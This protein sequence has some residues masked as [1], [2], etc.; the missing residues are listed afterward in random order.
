[1]IEGLG[2]FDFDYKM[3]YEQSIFKELY[4]RSPI[5]FVDKV[6]DSNF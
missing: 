6:I 4:Q 2:K 1:M 3:N 5:R